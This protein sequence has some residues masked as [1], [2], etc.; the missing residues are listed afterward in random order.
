MKRK[1]PALADQLLV[2][3]RH[4][5]A[6][7]YLPR[8]ARCLAMLTQ[9]EIWWR[10]HPSSNSIGNLILH[11]DGNVRQ[12]IISGLGRAPD[13]RQR[14]TEFAERGPIPRTRLLARLRSTV[15]EACAVVGRLTPQELERKRSIQS[16]HVS[17][18]R[19]LVHVVEHFAF[20]SG[21]IIL[22]TKMKRRRDLRFTRLR[23]RR[24]KR[25]RTKGLPVI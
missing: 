12:W 23:G 19:A 8:I 16:F 22:V 25:R 4:L 18:L 1:R 10:P 5:L 21:Q 14:D 3:A 9:E 20:H 6:D 17:G 15:E 2:Y 7:H 24:T 13:R 11:L